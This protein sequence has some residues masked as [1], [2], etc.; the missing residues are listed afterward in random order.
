MLRAQGIPSRVA[1]GLVYVEGFGAEGYS[2]GWHMWTQALVDGRWVDFD[3]TL[4]RRY[5]AAHV[6]T[7]VS[8]LGDQA[9]PGE[10]ASMMRMIGNLQIEV[11]DVE[12][13]KRRSD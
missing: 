1:T 2:F 3:A 4:S 7:G 12:A 6:L 5:H 13:T 9:A 8:S 11:V 10:M